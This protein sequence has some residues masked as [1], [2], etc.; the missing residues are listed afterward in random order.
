MSYNIE[1]GKYGVRAGKDSEKMWDTEATVAKF[2][3]EFTAF[4]EL[5]ERDTAKIEAEIENL[6]KPNPQ[7]TLNTPAMIGLVLAKIGFTMDTHAALTERCQEVLKN[8]PR[9]YTVKGQNGGRKRMS[10]EEFTAYKDSGKTPVD[11]ARDEKE[12]ERIA[13]EVKR[14]AKAAKASK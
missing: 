12:E 9:Y 14:A 11:M 2:T 13:K 3:K 10:D 4:V 1:M 8:N 5:Q 7:A 6:Y